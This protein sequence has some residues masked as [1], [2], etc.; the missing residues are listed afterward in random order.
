M[1]VLL[2]AASEKQYLFNKALHS[3]PALFGLV[4]YQFRFP[5][6]GRFE[7]NDDDITN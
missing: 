6:V 1:K 7:I 5:K 3:T 2:P 4:R